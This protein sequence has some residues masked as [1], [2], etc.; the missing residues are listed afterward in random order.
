MTS[1][2]RRYGNVKENKVYTIISQ[3]IQVKMENPDAPL[4]V[5]VNGDESAERGGDQNEQFC[6]ASFGA[7]VFY[8]SAL[9]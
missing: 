4:R 5:R 1:V 6:S 9:C 3:C 7:S 8:V 2:F